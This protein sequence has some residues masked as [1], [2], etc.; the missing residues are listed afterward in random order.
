MVQ[1]DENKIPNDESVMV[2]KETERIQNQNRLDKLANNKT[3]LQNVEMRDG[4]TDLVRACA[5]FSQDVKEMEL[6]LSP[7]DRVSEE[8]YDVLRCTLPE[9]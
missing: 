5:S 3:F 7:S 8:E 4:L 9:C 6:V 1:R 2:R